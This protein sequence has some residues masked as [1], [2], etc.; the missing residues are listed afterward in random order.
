MPSLSAEEAPKLKPY[1]ELA[2]KLGS[3]VGQLS[4]GAIAGLSIETEGAAAE[5]NM[6]PITGAV[7]AGFMR[8]HSDT[9]NMVNA[10][11]LARERGWTCA[12]CGTIARAITTRC[13]A[14]PPRP[15][16]AT[17]RYPAPCSAM[18]RRGWV[19]LF[20]IK[21]EADLAGDMLYIVNEDAPGFIGRLGTTLAK[22]TSTSAPSTSAARMP[23]ARPCC[24]CRSMR[25]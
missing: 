14:S 9:V 19:E 12:R 21:V 24:C 15:R 20:G 25:R 11:F 2:E 18:R 23:A 1:M 3:L 4:H 22:R 16:P 7:L 13:C 6:K 17:A 10:P 8:V 5:L